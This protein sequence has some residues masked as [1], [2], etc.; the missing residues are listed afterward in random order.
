MKQ[1]SEDELTQGRVGVFCRLMLAG[2]WLLKRRG[3]GLS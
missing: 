2:A 3:T 1:E